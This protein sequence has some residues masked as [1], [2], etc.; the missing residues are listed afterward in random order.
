MCTVLLSEKNPVLSYPTNLSFFFLLS[1][2]T[3]G[4]LTGELV[5][6]EELFIRWLQIATFLPVISFH[7]PPWA[8]GEDRVQKAHKAVTT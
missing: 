7:T 5:T 4:S 8:C 6:D 3:G 1:L 2:L